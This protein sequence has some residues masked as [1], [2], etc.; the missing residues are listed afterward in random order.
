MCHVAKVRFS[1][2]VALSSYSTSVR[3]SRVF[4]LQAENSSKKTPLCIAA[5]EGQVEIVKLFHSHP[6]ILDK[7]PKNKNNQTPLHWAAFNGH[8]NVS[9][10]FLDNS[11][12]NDKEPKDWLECT[13]MHWAAVKG[14]VICDRVMNSKNSNQVLI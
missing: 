1:R 11:M 5:E 4:Q 12:I 10:L 2:S 7:N 14:K 9:K 3:V 6:A 8:E 13:P